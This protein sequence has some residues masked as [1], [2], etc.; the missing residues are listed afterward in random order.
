MKVSFC[1]TCMGRAHHLRQTLARNLADTV[2]WVRPE[3]VEFV[4]VDYSSPDDLVEWF[5]D[6]PALA[7]YRERGILR[8]VRV[9][10]QTHFRH[11]HAK[12]LAHRA[13]TGDIVCNVD[14]DNFVGAGFD[15]YLRA[16]FTRRPRSVVA[17][18]R[19]DRGLVDPR[20]Q[21]C[22]GRVALRR[23]D[24]DALGGYDE[25]DRFR[26]WS[27]EDHDLLLRAVRS[28]LVPV[29][30]RDRRFLEVVT[31]SDL[32]RVAFTEHEDVGAELAR[33]GSLDGSRMVPVLRHVATR[34]R[35]PRVANA[36][37]RRVG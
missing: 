20:W 14:A 12:N 15:A 23:T 28:R 18:S 30:L 5:E 8:L 36:G 11:S 22:M 9:P 13:A 31:H 4:V 21:G 32:E 2:S 37:G 6:D 24:F 1:T 27:G 17:T 16:V 29:Q 26:G 7:P 33:V 35:V 3:A 19:L 10:H 34:L 25:S